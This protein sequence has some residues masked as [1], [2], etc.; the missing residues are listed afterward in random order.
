MKTGSS[1]E[2]PKLNKEV[3]FERLE[4]QL[5]ALN[6]L[7]GLIDLDIETSREEVVSRLDEVIEMSKPKSRD[8]I[9]ELEEQDT[10]TEKV[11]QMAKDEGDDLGEDFRDS[12]SLNTY[13]GENAEVLFH[14]KIRAMA[15]NLKR[16]NTEAVN[17]HED[18]AG[19]SQFVHNKMIEMLGSRDISVVLSYADIDKM[20]ERVSAFS[21][22]LIC[23]RDK[24]WK[25][26]GDVLIGDWEIKETGGIHVTN[27]SVNIICRGSEEEMNLTM[28]HE[29]IHNFVD[30]RGVMYDSEKEEVLEELFEEYRGYIEEPEHTEPQEST[31]EINKAKARES[32]D[33]MLK[34]KD[35]LDSH[36]EEL[37]ASMRSIEGKEFP[38][39]LENEAG[40]TEKV[41]MFNHIV[42]LLE[43]S[44][45]RMS[46]LA[47]LIDKVSD[48]CIEEDTEF[49]ALLQKRLDAFKAKVVDAVYS[50]RE[51]LEH[52]KKLG[53][54]AYEEVHLLL[55]L[56]PPSK[57]R[58]IP[59]RFIE[60]RYS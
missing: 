2:K 14:L 29:R 42:F 53:D 1:G 22:D 46:R 38:E 58:Y 51:L 56:L 18:R 43:T 60:S 8:A 30:F 11:E 44:G 37:L 59:K 26:V 24:F 5:E 3:L 52:S 20:V 15:N 31:K 9:D 39:A 33:N 57:W 55:A 45:E 32:I 4:H 12:N 50:A 49:F 25:M 28:R 10:V 47:E 6:K 40:Q 23:S 19:L 34:D 21:I 54:E 17:F 36:H 13:V 27:S 35:L 48:E 41:L 16:K 7:K